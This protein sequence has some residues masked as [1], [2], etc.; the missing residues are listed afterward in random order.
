MGSL[1]VVKNGKSRS[2]G[3]DDH[4]AYALEAAIHPKA[5]ALHV[6]IEAP[7]GVPAARPAT[8]ATLGLACATGAC[9]LM[10]MRDR[11]RPFVAS[12]GR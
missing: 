3:A 12:L 7:E 6:G 11:A 2:V 1:E 5:T 8:W 9:A 4:G 10:E